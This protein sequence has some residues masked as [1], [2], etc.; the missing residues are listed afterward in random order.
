MTNSAQADLAEVVRQELVPPPQGGPSVCP[1][2]RSWKDRAEA[3]D[4]SNCGDIAVTL[5]VPA[6]NLSV[7]TLYRKPSVLRD[8]LTFYKKGRRPEEAA[9]PPDLQAQEHVRALIHEFLQTNSQRLRASYGDFDAVVVVPSTDRPPPHPLEMMLAGTELAS[10]PGILRRTGAPLGF[11]Q[12]SA[13][14]YEAISSVSGD[15]DDRRI[16]LVDDVYTTGA[17]INSAAYALSNAGKQVVGALVLARRVNP[18][19]HPDV[20]RLWDEQ[21]RKPYDWSTSPYICEAAP[22]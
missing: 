7:V 5:G 14:A 12:P 21:R 11:R 18:D 22:Q 9:P 10:T 15:G 17:R 6:L 19:F 16:L 2:C 1:R 20:K 8:W 4:C 3:E 13:D